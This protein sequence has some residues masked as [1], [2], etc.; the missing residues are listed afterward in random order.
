MVLNRAI[1]GLG[2]LP[3]LV[4]YCWDMDM[5]LA[6][7]ANGTTKRRDAPFNRM[8][9]PQEWWKASCTTDRERLYVQAFNAAGMTREVI[10]RAHKEVDRYIVQ[11]NV[12]TLTPEEL[13]DQAGPAQVRYVQIDVEGMDK[14]IVKALPFG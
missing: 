8:H 14:E 13:I 2:Q 3:K 4:L 5:V 1:H 6:L 12:D 7:A 9:K 11:H 10:E